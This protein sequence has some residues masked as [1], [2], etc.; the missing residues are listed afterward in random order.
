MN[1]HQHWLKEKKIFI[2]VYSYIKVYSCLKSVYSYYKSDSCMSIIEDTCNHD[3]KRKK[4]KLN[5]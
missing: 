1:M 5:S 3:G 2:T 4:I